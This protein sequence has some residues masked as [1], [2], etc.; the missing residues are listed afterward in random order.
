MGLVLD[1]RPAVFEQH[2]DE[3]NKFDTYMGSGNRMKLLSLFKRKMGYNY[4]SPSFEGMY[5][6]IRKGVGIITGS[7]T[8]VSMHRVIAL[9]KLRLN[10]LLMSLTC[11]S[12]VRL[13]CRKSI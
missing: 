9:S 3:I 1:K 11:S 10:T 4:G 6:Q 8:N 7:A 12:G 5:H 2:S 13:T